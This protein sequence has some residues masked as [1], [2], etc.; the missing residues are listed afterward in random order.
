MD[1]IY[2]NG[3]KFYGYH[4]VLE[5]ET[6]LGQLFYVDIVVY[7]DL[8]KAGQTDALE[9]TINYAHI[10]NRAKDIVEGEP[11]KLI[12]AVAERIVESIFQ[13][14]DLAEEIVVKVTKPTPPI[15]GHYDSV[16]VEVRRQRK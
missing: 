11:Y 1:K 7:V 10:Y 2:F 13:L 15:P 16:A 3:M 4:G 8:Q 5:E 9:E 14:S 12:E 6:R